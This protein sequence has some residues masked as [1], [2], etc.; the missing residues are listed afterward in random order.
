AASDDDVDGPGDA[1]SLQDT[2]GNVRKSYGIDSDV[3]LLVRPDGYIAS[4]ATHDALAA[5]RAA[6]GALT[7]PIRDLA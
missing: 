1:H 7:P 3:L 2:A 5:T 4:I 6:I